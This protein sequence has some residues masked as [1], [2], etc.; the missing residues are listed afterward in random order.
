MIEKLEPGHYHL[1][2][3]EDNIQR[4]Q[5]PSPSPP[6][7][8]LPHPVKERAEKDPRHIHQGEDED[9]NPSTATRQ[10][11]AIHDKRDGLRKDESYVVRHWT[12]IRSGLRNGKRRKFQIMP[13]PVRKTAIAV[14]TAEMN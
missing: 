2:S 1:G 4:Q 3:E 13:R 14:K 10:H 7:S 5:S 11:H 6:P 9:K 8:H 12:R